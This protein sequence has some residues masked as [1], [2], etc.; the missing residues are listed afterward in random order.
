[1]GGLKIQRVALCL[2][3]L[4]LVAC[5]APE[6]PRV[7]RAATTPLVDLNVLRTKIPPVLLEARE[8]PYLPPAEGGCEAIAAEIRRLDDA[9][10]PDLD[11]AKEEGENGLVAQGGELAGELAIDAIEDVASVV[12]FRRWVRKLSGAERASKEVAAAVAAG[13]AR[14]SFL[15]GL[16]HG[17]ACAPPGT[18]PAPEG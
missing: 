1:M 12:P 16:A 4:A 11:A 6:K 2:A 18:P 9:L 5:A 17:W 15:K 8:A 13:R 7:V 10:G 14:R 3:A